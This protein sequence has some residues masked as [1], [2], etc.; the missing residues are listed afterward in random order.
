[1][2]LLSVAEKMEYAAA[3]VSYHLA[4]EVLITSYQN[5]TDQFSSSD[6]VTWEDQKASKRSTSLSGYKEPRQKQQSVAT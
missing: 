1:M 2:A 3:L 4:L 6:S 5:L